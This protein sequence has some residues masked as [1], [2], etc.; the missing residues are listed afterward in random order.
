MARTERGIPRGKIKPFG[1]T[2]QDALFRQSCE[3][4]AHGGRAGPLDIRCFDQSS[5]A[6]MSTLQ[7]NLWGSE[8]PSRTFFPDGHAHIMTLNPNFVP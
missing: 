6:G 2:L 1:D 7:R 4:L 5:V 8:T 3:R